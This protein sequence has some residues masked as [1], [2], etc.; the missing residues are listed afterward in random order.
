MSEVISIDAVE[1]IEISISPDSAI[2][3]DAPENELDIELSVVG[4]QGPDGEQGAPGIQGPVG[5]PV[6]TTEIVIDG[7]FF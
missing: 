4:Q 5:P 7:G 3:I 6:N 2:Q 1:E